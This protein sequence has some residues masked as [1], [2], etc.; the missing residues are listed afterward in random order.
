MSGFKKFEQ[1]LSDVEI[2]GIKH[3]KN[4]RERHLVL[5]GMMKGVILSLPIAV[6]FPLRP[7]TKN[8][9][10]ISPNIPGDKTK[11]PIHH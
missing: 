3:F 8:A 10:A 9:V 7:L 4:F 5:D 6:Y 1:K 11:P 2:K